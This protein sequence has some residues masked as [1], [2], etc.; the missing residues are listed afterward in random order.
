[1]S[2]LYE[3]IN[4]VIAVLIS[5]S[6]GLPNHNASI[7]LCV[8]KLRILIEDSDQNLKYLGLL[9]MSKILKTHPKSVQA[10]KDLVLTCLEDKDESIRLRALDLLYGMVSKK[11]LMDI[12]RRLLVNVT[13]NPLGNKYRDELIVK[14]IDI[15][16][17]ND[18]ALITN[19]EWYISVMV[20]LARVDGGTEHGS[21]IAIQLLDVAIRVE[22]IRPY[23]T[24]QMSVLLENSGMFSSNTPVCEV[25]AAAAWIVG[26]FSEH[27]VD[28]KKVLFSLVPDTRFPLH[29]ETA[30]LHNAA[31]IYSE[32]HNDMSDEERQRLTDKLQVYVN[33]DDI[34]VQERASNFQQ[35]INCIQDLPTDQVSLFKAYP[36]N[37]VAAKAQKKVPVPSGLDLDVEFYVQE[38]HSTNGDFDDRLVGLATGD[39]DT[40]SGKKDKKKKKKKK[41]KSATDGKENDDK[42]STG[43]KKSKKKSDTVHVDDTAAATVVDETPKKVKK[44]KVK[45]KVE[46]ATDALKQR[47]KSLVLP[48]IPGLSS[49][50]NFINTSVKKNGKRKSSKKGS[51]KNNDADTEATSTDGGAARGNGD[52]GDLM[53]VDRDDG[54]I[55]QHKVT[56]KGHEMPEGTIDE[57]GNSD[58]DTARVNW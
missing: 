53:Q 14:I 44:K 41:D 1:M 9:A 46:D 25:L 31:K 42:V 27:L 36:L 54:D 37:P 40:A 17:Q 45:A 55:M 8:Q 2:L 28:K 34:E 52:G 33:T 12:V 43:K 19:F 7:Q 16:S 21:L 13:Q 22:T 4:T 58:D 3:C 57:D 32:V 24:S 23:A 38:T 51:P 39:A 11:N 5:I 49:S 10:H 47:E 26:E 48:E 56:L 29:I 35:L 20:D 6:H 30:F 50:S 15:C 18:Y